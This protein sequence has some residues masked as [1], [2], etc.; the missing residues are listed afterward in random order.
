MTSFKK[1]Y[2][3]DKIYFAIHDKDQFLKDNDV[4]FNTLSCVYKTST[5]I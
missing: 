3:I 2:I 4:Y 5:F 1:N